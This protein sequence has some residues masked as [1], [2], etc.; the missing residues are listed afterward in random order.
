MRRDLAALGQKAED[1]LDDPRK[2]M[3]IKRGMTIKR[4]ELA[5]IKADMQSKSF[6][7]SRAERAG[8]PPGDVAF[9]ATIGGGSNYPETSTTLVAPALNFSQEDVKA[10][11]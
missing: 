11:L 2:S 7:L 3:T 9:G 1:L 4:F 6:D 8:G 5:R 10:A